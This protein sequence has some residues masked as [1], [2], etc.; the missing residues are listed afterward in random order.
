METDSRRVKKYAFARL[1]VLVGFFLIGTV[2]QGQA[3]GMGASSETVIALPVDGQVY[4]GEV[5]FADHGPLDRG[6]F[7]LAGGRYILYLV[8]VEPGEDYTFGLRL[9][10][11]SLPQMD[12][13]VFDRWPYAKDVKIQHLPTGGTLMGNQD[14]IE[15]QWRIGVSA[16]SPGNLLYLGVDLKKPLKAEYRRFPVRVFMTHPAIDPMHSMG[17]GVT[18]ARGPGNLML[19]ERENPVRVVQMAQPEPG[20]R[21]SNQQVGAQSQGLIRNDRFQKGLTSWNVYPGTRNNKELGVSVG[22]QGLRLW[23]Q[24]LL[25][26]RGVEQLFSPRVRPGPMAHLALELRIDRQ[27][28]REKLQVLDAF[29]LRLDLICQP[30]EKTPNT[31]ARQFSHVFSIVRPEKHS[32]LNRMVTTIPQ[33]LWYRYDIDLP[34]VLPQDC[35]LERIRLTGGGIPERDVRIR[36]VQIL[37]Q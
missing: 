21:L 16:Q 14:R 7:S 25:Q 19:Q 24:D 36:Q 5:D 22:G 2:V 30:A 23:S 10:N 33:N 26:S 13:V 8:K 4:Y 12:V 18:Y 17:R 37:P 9:P 32:P 20:W 1:L 11:M 6:G 27:T 31:T 35:L 34:K 15:Y 3:V 28:Q 29:P